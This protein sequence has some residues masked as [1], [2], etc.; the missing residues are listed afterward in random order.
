MVGSLFRYRKL[1]VDLVTAEGAVCV[2]YASSLQLLG[3]ELQS[4]G[5][6]WYPAT[7]GRYVHRAVGPAR[8]DWASGAVR[9]AFETRRGSFALELEAKVASNAAA[10]NLTPRL[11]W[12]VL[13]SKAEAAVR[14]LAAGAARGTGYADCVEMT[15]PPR[16]LGLTSLQW[17]RGHAQ[18]TAESF[19]FTQA[20]FS[21]GRLFRSALH[22]DQI[23]GPLELRS[24]EPAALEVRI[25]EAR[26]NLS[27]VRVLHAGSALDAARFPSLA[28]RTLARVC[29]GPVR[30]TRWLAHATF[31][32]GASGLALHERVLF[33]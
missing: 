16:A 5:Y 26:C 13:T 11:S 12:Q 30:E 10:A 29:S 7:G 4:A 27:A 17:G 21:D 3:R 15:V 9:L 14:G 23:S 8:I 31:P 24:T 28:E 32:S 20:Q 22:D 33:G 25:A 18:K 19:V 2:G 6:E 1:Y